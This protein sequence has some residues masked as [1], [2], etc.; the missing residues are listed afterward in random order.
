MIGGAGGGG[1]GK[2]GKVKGGG[3]LSRNG[4]LPY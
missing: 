4:E 3:W 2:R 1:P